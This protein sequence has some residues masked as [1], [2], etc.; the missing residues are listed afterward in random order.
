MS[1]LDQFYA[2]KKREIDGIYEA[3]RDQLADLFIDGPVCHV[4]P[5]TRWQRV[6]FRVAVW[7]YRIARAWDALRGIEHDD[8]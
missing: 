6:K 5:P 1:D 4:P 2:D 7:L 8:G 3:F